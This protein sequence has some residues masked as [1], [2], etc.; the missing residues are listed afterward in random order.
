MK[1]LLIF[2]AFAAAINLSLSGWSLPHPA[3]FLADDK[4][5]GGPADLFRVVR[6]IDGD[7]IDVMT[8]VTSGQA[9]YTEAGQVGSTRTERV[10]YI[11]ID[12]PETVDPRKS[13]QC[14]GA[15]AA[16]KNKELVL[17]KLVRLEKGV[18]GLD[19]YGRLLRYV[20]LA[21]QSGASVNLELVREGYARVFIYPPDT[22]YA[23]SFINAEKMARA[24]GLGLWK[25]CP[26]SK[27]EMF[28]RGTIQ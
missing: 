6:V 24:E 15:E 26:A 22:E 5:A 20:Y 10:R 12:A 14:F 27:G 11:G 9:L 8:S 21:G 16:E 23:G 25:A 18:D 2:L 13:A 4:M 19:K 7:T 17:G 28:G 1:K 3:E